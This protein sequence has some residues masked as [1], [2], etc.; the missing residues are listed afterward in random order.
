MSKMPLAA[1]DS[2]QKKARYGLVKLAQIIAQSPPTGRGRF[3][4]QIG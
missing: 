2:H 3:A 4:Q 1:A